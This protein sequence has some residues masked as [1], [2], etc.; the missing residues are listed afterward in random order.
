MKLIRAQLAFWVRHPEPQG[1]PRRHSLD[2]E[3]KWRP[4]NLSKQVEHVG[5]SNVA[6]FT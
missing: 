2:V 1:G 6:M 4:G 5:V 3:W